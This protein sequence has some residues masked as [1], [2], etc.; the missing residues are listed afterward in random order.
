MDINAIT[1]RGRLPLDAMRGNAMLIKADQSSLLIIDVQTGLAPVMTDP[2]RVCR[3]CRILMQAASRLKI[4]LLV[5]EQYPKGLGRTVSAL[6]PFIPD[7]AVAE[8]LHFSCAADPGIRERIGATARKQLV[9]AGIESHIC[10]FQSA[11][12]F[13]ELG[14][15]VIVAADA[16]ASRKE[17]S[18]TTSMNRLA[19][20][21]VVVATVEMVVF[22]WLHRAGTPEFKELSALVK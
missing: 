22:E 10:V 16:C 8:K 13:K 9:I 21:G 1:A 15:D 2:E 11:V 4:P 17:L 3:G 6:Q 12:G 5:S 20:N 19:A 18:W 7:G 14:Y